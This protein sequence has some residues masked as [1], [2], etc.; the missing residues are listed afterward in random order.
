MFTEFCVYTIVSR[1]KLDPIALDQAPLVN[2]EARTWKAAD[3]MLNEARAAG[4]SLPLVLADAKD[5]S[6]LLY[7]G[8]LQVLKLSD[9]RTEY[10]VDYLRSLPGRHSPQELVLRSTGEHIAPGFIR[11]YA[12]CLTPPFL[13]AE[14]D[15]PV[16]LPEEGRSEGTLTEGAAIQVTV[17]AYERSPAAR[18]ACVERYG[19]RCSVCGFDFAAT[20]GEIGDGFIHVHHLVPLGQIGEEYEVDPVRDL[21][22]VCA[23][24]HAMIHRARPALDLDALRIRISQR[25]SA[26]EQGVAPD[27]RPRT[28]ARG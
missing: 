19:Y 2:S 22:P 7:W 21:R 12:I 3:T 27:E 9:Q 24:C 4:Q 20:Y 25:G 11:P 13:T 5:C 26:A 1:D 6:R 28:A 23:N 18:R 17:N 10:T 8:I 15:A 16:L 14:G